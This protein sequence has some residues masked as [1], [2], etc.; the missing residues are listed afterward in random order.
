MCGPS[1]DKALRLA[2]RS[3]YPPCWGP[4]PGSPTGGPRFGGTPLAPQGGMG[5]WRGHKPKFGQRKTSCPALTDPRGRWSIQAEAISSRSIRPPH[6]T[7]GLTSAEVTEG[8]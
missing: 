3:G 7:D 2:C 6:I 4:Q 5:G 8:L 1:R